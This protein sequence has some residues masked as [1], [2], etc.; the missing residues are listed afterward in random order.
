M[1]ERHRFED[2]IQFQAAGDMEGADQVSKIYDILQAQ[3][4]AR[5]ELARFDKETLAVQERIKANREQDY[6]L[7][8]AWS[9]A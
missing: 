1:L 5:H 8:K 4:D 6:L 3:L 7:W 9:D 2:M